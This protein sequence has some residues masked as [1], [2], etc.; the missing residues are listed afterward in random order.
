M[1][2]LAGLVDLFGRAVAEVVAE[3]QVSAPPSLVLYP[4]GTN[5]EVYNTTTQVWEKR[6]GLGDN[7]SANVSITLWWEC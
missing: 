3:G 4:D 1:H 7:L 2:K 6:D 5:G